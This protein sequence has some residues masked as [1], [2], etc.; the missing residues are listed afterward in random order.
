VEVGLQRAAG[1][2]KAVS[3]TPELTLKPSTETPWE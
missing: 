1:W 2:C 3:D